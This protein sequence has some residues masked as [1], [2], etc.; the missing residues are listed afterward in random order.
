MAQASTSQAGASGA[1]QGGV[2]NRRVP[3]QKS[4]NCSKCETTELTKPNDMNS[5]NQN[6]RGMNMPS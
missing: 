6:V 4:L 2:L 1:V 3:L 5:L